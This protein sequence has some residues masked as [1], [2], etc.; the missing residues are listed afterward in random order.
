MVA[1]CTGFE[2]FLQHWCCLPTRVYKHGQINVLAFSGGSG[3]LI[4]YI[5]K[6]PERLVNDFTIVTSKTSH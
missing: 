6:S 1:T 2:E 3:M 5:T 4:F